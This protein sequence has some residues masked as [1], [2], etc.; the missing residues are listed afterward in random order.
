V[1]RHLEA[2]RIDDHV[3]HAELLESPLNPSF[4][5]AR[6]NSRAIHSPS[7]CF[8]QHSPQRRD[9][10]V[11][12]LVVVDRGSVRTGYMGSRASPRGPELPTLTGSRFRIRGSD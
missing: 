6:L 3:A 1:P 11:P 2:R 8:P 7:W 4:H 12:P 10:W 9:P 5:F